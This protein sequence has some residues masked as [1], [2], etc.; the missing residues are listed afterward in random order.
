MDSSP[1][2]PRQEDIPTQRKNE[3]PLPPEAFPQ[4]WD[5]GGDGDTEV[6]VVY[7]LVQSV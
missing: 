4:D 2:P 5:P 1:K 7:D 3:K 6:D